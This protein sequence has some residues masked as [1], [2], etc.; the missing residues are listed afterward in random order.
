MKNITHD[1]FGGTQTIKSVTYCPMCHAEVKVV[2]K[3]TQ[4]YEPVEYDKALDDVI[5][6]LTEMVRTKEMGYTYYADIK[7]E[8]ENLR[9]DRK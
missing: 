3:T 1:N 7:K 6:K 4:H 2:G 9:K 8:I 5:G